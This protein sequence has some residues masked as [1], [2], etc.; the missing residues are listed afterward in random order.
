MSRS[1]TVI[2]YGIGNILNVV[3]AFEQIGAD[4]SLAKSS[5]DLKQVERVVL[6]GVGAF[7]H[8]MNQLKD[9]AIIERIKEISDEGIPLLGICL[10][11]QMLLSYSEEHGKTKGLGVIPGK[12]IAVP[13]CG[14]DNTAHKI[15]HIGWNELKFSG[16][17]VDWNSTL[18][19]DIDVNSPVYFVHSFMAVPDDYSMRV[20]DCEY[21]GQPI[22]A[23]VQK[24]NVMGCQFH[25]EKSGEVGLH[26]LRTFISI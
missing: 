22:C 8:G 6:P 21:D 2:D 18:L 9:L 24:D 23:V 15:P 3:R 13:D 25:P 19:A 14:I 12:V 1:V 17:R 16:N 10:G 20:A 4:V 26:I 5:S 11:M 7:S